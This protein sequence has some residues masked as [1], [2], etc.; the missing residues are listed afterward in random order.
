MYNVAFS[1][2]ESGSTLK[3]SIY[4][5]G[6]SEMIGPYRTHLPLSNCLILL[7]RLERRALTFLLARP[8]HFL[9]EY[10]RQDG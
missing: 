4:H 7:L 1:G 6:T 8:D 3:F 9:Q 5:D 2:D 10:Q